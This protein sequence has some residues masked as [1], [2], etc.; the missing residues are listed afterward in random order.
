M[1]VPLVIP[2]HQEHC[3]QKLLVH[4]GN[5]E[6]LQTLCLELFM[7]VALTQNQEVNWPQWYVNTFVGDRGIYLVSIACGFT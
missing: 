4:K 5:D 3:S 1:L 6:A 7:F 2:S